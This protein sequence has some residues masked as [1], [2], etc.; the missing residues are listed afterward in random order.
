MAFAPP[1][2]ADQVLFTFTGT[3][4]GTTP[5]F[6]MD[7]PWELQW[8]DEGGLFMALLDAPDGSVVDTHTGQPPGGR[9]H[10]PDGGDFF[11]IVGAEHRWTVNIVSVG[12]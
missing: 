2:S 4:N 12:Q 1:A 5:S 10:Q 3:A 11:L 8:T 9:A 6:H 7:G